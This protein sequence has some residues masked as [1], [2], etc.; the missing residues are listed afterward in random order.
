MHTVKWYKESD[1][2]I[3]H[4]LSDPVPCALLDASDESSIIDNA[5]EDLPALQRI[6][7]CRGGGLICVLRHGARARVAHVASFAQG[8]A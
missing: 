2:S 1:L 5:V 3:L 4:P 6:E 7:A 8:G